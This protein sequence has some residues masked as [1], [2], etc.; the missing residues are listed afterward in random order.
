MRKTSPMSV[1]QPSLTLSQAA[2]DHALDM[3]KNGREGHTGSD[4]STLP[5]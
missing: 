2:Q 5:D 1:L 4:G 3:G